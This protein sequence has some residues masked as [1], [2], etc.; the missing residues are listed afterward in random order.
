MNAEELRQCF[1]WSNTKPDMRDRVIRAVEDGFDVIV[2]CTGEVKPNTVITWFDYGYVH[3][4]D[5]GNFAFRPDWD[6][7]D[8]SV[9]AVQTHQGV[10]PCQLQR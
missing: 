4:L 5:A 3:P 8:E 9:I 6:T 2:A 7:L 10:Q 1:D